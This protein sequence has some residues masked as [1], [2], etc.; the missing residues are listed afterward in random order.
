[1]FAFAISTTGF[2][3]L[4]SIRCVVLFATSPTL[5]LVF[6]CCRAMAIGMAFEAWIDVKVW[7]I[8]LGLEFLVVDHEPYQDTFVCCLGIIHEDDY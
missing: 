1:M 5:F 2:I 3:S 8:L 4:A 6:A 7:G